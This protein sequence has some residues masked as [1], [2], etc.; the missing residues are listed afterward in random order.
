MG[1]YFS[2]GVY[3]IKC[4]NANNEVLYETTNQVKYTGEEINGIFQVL[5]NLPKPYDVYLYKQYST[6]YKLDTPPAFMWIKSHF[7]KNLQDTN[8]NEAI[9]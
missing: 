5:N 9:Q 3:G 6:T 1:I 2:E 7:L 8:N 4:V